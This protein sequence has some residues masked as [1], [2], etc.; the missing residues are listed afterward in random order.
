MYVHVCVGKG[1]SQRPEE[2]ICPMELELQAVISCPMWM[3]GSSEE[4]L[5]TDCVHMHG[6]WRL[7]LEL[8]IN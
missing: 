1:C 8:C 7:N 4:L 3:L 5:S 2:G 6:N